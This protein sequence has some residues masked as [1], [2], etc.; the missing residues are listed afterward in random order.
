M[1]DAENLVREAHPMFIIGDTETAGFGEYKKACEVALQV[2]DPNTLEPLQEYSSILNPEC[3]IQE[4]AAA[5]HGI[6]QEMVEDE[7]TMDQFVEQRLG[8][9]FT[10]DIIIIAHNAPFDV[11][12]LTPIGNIVGQICTLSWARRLITDTKDHKLQTLREHFGIP[13]NNAH[14]ALDD[15]HITRQ[16]LQQLVKLSGKTLMQMAL[17]AEYTVHAM[18]FGKYKGR[19]LMGLPK[20]YIEYMLTLDLESNLRK[21]LQKVLKV[22]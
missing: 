7:P 11:P 3:E 5:I 17:A 16:V 2:I 18:P 10:T 8:G 14:R 15:V 22:K 9:K 21:S 19:P 20:D 6:T 12:L 4:S 1:E 13:E